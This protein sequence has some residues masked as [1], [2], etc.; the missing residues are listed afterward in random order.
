MEPGHAHAAPM[1]VISQDTVLVQ[2]WIRPR[3]EQECENWL[4]VALVQ[5]LADRHG[6]TLAGRDFN[7]VAR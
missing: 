1:L 2:A 6:E 3:R 4:A 7:S 5:C